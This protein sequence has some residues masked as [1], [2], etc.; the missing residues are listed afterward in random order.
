MTFSRHTKSKIHQSSTLAVVDIGTT[1]SVCYIAHLDAIGDIKVVGVGHQLSKGIRSGHITDIVDAETSIVAVVHA[2]E[3]MT[4][5]TIENVVVNVSSGQIQSKTVS[6]ELSLGG[7]AVT[8]R[9]IIDVIRE[10]R[11][12][13]EQE[14]FEIL[15]TIPVNYSLDHVKNIKDPRGMVGDMLGAEIHMLSAPDAMLRNLT[16]CFAR[17]HLNVTECVVAAHASSL[18]VLEPDEM[19]LG[20]TVIDLG[21]GTTNFSVFANGKNVFSDAIAIGGNHVTS[22]LA[23]GLSTSI[24]H[25]E[26]LK[27]LHGSAVAAA[28]DDQAM[29][30]VPQLGEEDDSEDGNLLPRS[31]LVGIIRPRLEEMFELIRGKIEASGYDKIAGRRVVL[32]GGGSQML[33]IRDLA[34]RVLG[35]Q[36]RLGKP[37]SIQ[38]LGDAVG[39][40]AFSTAIGMLEYARRKALEGRLLDPSRF[41]TKGFGKIMQWIKENF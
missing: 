28:A 21:G 15:H 20:V 40:P 34:T 30:D 6:V 23:K 22:D 17:C 29:I 4:D 39:G 38:G 3:Q 19:D 26:R 31:M 35:K 36:V 18:A 10:G 13:V 32:T 11:K 9:D 41:R 37:R 8:E 5:E 2:A 25:A 14:E 16:N 1:K 27:T 12:S 7:E 24:A 33:G